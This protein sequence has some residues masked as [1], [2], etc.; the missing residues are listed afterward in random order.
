VH[1]NFGN[2]E[3]RLGLTVKAVPDANNLLYATGTSV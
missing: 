3:R 1:S 2:V